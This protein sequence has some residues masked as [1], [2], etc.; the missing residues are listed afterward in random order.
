MHFGATVAWSDWQ[1]LA[2]RLTAKGADFRLVPTVDEV[3]GQAKMMLADPDGYLVEL[4]AY[5]DEA[6]LTG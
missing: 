4:K 1:A 3:R 2:D 6:T 5:R